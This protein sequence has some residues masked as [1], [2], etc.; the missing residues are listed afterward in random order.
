[1]QTNKG[2]FEKLFDLSFS[3]FI[4]PQIVGVLYILGLLIGALF[5]LWSVFTAFMVAGFVEG[6]GMLVFGLIGLL[7]Y[8]IFLRVS[9]ESFV[10]IIRTAESTRVLAEDVLSKRGIEQENG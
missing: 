10:A 3:S 7:I 9:L 2:F 4:A 6:V 5:T 1:M 8:A